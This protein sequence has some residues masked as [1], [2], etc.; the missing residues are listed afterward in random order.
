[1]KNSNNF[2]KERLSRAELQK[3]G[4][5]L[6]GGIIVFFGLAFP[7]LWGGGIRLSSWPWLLALMLA[8]ISMTAPGVLRPVNK[9]WLLIGKILGYINSRIILGVIYLVIFTPIAILLMLLGKDSMRR[10]FDQK[11][12][13]Y[14][15][16]SRQP[17]P[18]N[19]NRPF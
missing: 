18:E 3:F 10:A 15:I 7:L 12:N 16:D 19:L 14:R 4:L 17:K 13:S 9:A 1:M 2:K 5:I 6:S 11:A 8:A